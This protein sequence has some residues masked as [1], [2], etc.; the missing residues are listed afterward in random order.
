MNLQS[1]TK[2]E[3][4][5]AFGR[6]EE[7]YELDTD[8]GEDDVLFGSDLQEVTNDVLFY[9]ERDELPESYLLRRLDKA[10]FLARY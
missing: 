2:G 7:V 1:H 5:A 6:G 8:D 3:I 10:G 4:L 9:L